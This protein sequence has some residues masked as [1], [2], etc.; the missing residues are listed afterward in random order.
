MPSDAILTDGMRR[1]IC[2]ECKMQEVVV[3]TAPMRPAR[4]HCKH[5]GWNSIDGPLETDADW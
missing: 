1:A 3:Q 2:P 5:C 4:M